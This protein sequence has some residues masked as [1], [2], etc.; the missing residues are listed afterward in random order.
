MSSTAKLNQIIL[1]LIKISD[2]NII[3]KVIDRFKSEEEEAVVS[4]IP[5]A[6]EP[7]YNEIIKSEVQKNNIESIDFNSI[8]NK[9]DIRVIDDQPNPNIYSGEI[10]GKIYIFKEFMLN[11]PNE[12]KLFLDI[13]KEWKSFRLLDD[14]NIFIT[15][16]KIFYT[17]DESGNPIYN[18]YVMDYSDGTTMNKY[19]ADNI[20]SNLDLL[21]IMEQILKG[22]KKFYDKL[23]FYP[24]IEHGE[25]VMIKKE[26]ETIVIKLIDLDELIECRNKNYTEETSIKTLQLIL[27]YC[28]DLDKITNFPI[29][30]E[31]FTKIGNDY[32]IK[33]EYTTYEN[34][35]NKI[36]ELKQTSAEAAQSA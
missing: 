26:N 17:T 20:I 25:N 28:T 23:N 29:F 5:P 4:E 11:E 30:K 32:Q 2:D 24:C 33:S 19:C 18:G 22:F 9:E 16:K 34:I 12:S 8:Q 31:F 27:L 35:L 15:P 1:N 21:S 14:D 6:D 7:E 3:D 13:V 10:D 36:Y